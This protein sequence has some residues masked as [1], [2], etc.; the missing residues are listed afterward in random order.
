MQLVSIHDHARRAVIEGLDHLAFIE[1][2]VLFAAPT[3][4]VRRDAV[5]ALLREFRLGTE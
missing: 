4:A 3:P 5:E 2:H 1:G